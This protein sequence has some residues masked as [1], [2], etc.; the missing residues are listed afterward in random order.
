MAFVTKTGDTFVLMEKT[1]TADGWRDRR[2]ANLFQYE[3][4]ERAFEG[5]PGDADH[6]KEEIDQLNEELTKPYV[7]NRWG[8]KIQINEKLRQIDR[9][10]A[11]Y[12]K[13]ESYLKDT[14]PHIF[15]GMEAGI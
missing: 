9:L 1:K 11:A 6:L 4:P 10:A 7:D 3:T 12:E 2:I 14:S 8:I 13:I 5:I 15:H